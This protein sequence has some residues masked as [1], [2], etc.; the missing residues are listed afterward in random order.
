[1]LPALLLGSGLFS[2]TKSESALREDEICMRVPTTKATGLSEYEIFGVFLTA[3]DYPGGTAWETAWSGEQSY[4]LDAAFKHFDA[5]TLGTAQDFWAGCE[6]ETGNHRPYYYPLQGSLLAIGYS[7]HKGSSKAAGTIL[8]VTHNSNQQNQSAKNPL[9]IIGFRQNMDPGAMVNFKY[10][11]PAD[12]NSG[13]SFSKESASVP[14][15]FHYALCKVQFS[16]SSDKDWYKIGNV[17]LLGCVNEGTFYNANSP[18]FLPT[19]SSAVNEGYLLSEAPASLYGEGVTSPE[20]LLLP[21]YTDGVFTSG[22][23][24]TFIRLEFDVYDNDQ[25][26][27]QH[28]VLSLD[29]PATEEA[30]QDGVI[31]LSGL[32]KHW[33]MGKSYK[34]NIKINPRPIDFTLDVEVLTDL[35]VEM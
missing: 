26:S 2:C 33:E 9:L 34:Y 28:V 20:L 19:L 1:M 35:P 12:V 16:F 10:F 17:R 3:N 4:V 5:A 24:G 32:T 11:R 13:H 31:Y 18:G 27:S 25:F 21:Q 23:T 30:K 6:L 22:N 7:P 14:I 8:S 15:L 29:S